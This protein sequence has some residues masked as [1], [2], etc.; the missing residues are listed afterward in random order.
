MNWTKLHPTQSD[1]FQ[2]RATYFTVA[3]SPELQLY[4]AVTY[5]PQPRYQ[6]TDKVANPPWVT[7]NQQATLQSPN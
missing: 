6:D 3:L 4:S 2:I 5:Q 1:P 7:K